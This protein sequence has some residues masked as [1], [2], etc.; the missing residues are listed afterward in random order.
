MKTAKLL[1][2]T[3]LAAAAFTACRT[4]ETNYRQA[5]ERTVAARTEQDSLDNTI[6]GHERRN[7]SETKARTSTGEVT[8]KTQFVRVAQGCGLNENLHRYNAVVGQFK[9]IFNA[10]SMRERL[11]DAGFPAT[12]VVETAEPYYYIVIGS[13]N[14]IDEA[15][16]ELDKYRASG[17]TIGNTKEPFV[18]DATARR[19]PVSRKANK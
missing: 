10:R 15:A 5:Y 1:I 16:A 8:L 18:L 6:Y 9:Q 3:I 17:C 14:T 13:F 11:I 2:L 4:T 7:M 19:S 12:I